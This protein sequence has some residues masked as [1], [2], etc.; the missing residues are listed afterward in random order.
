MMSMLV[1][2]SNHYTMHAGVYVVC[3]YVFVC[4]DMY[5]HMHIEPRGQ[6][7]PHSRSTSGAFGSSLILPPPPS[8]TPPPPLLL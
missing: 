1:Y 6:S 2:Y 4:A 7:L 5:A 3:V 8:P